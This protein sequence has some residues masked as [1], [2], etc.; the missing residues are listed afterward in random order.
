MTAHPT[1]ARRRTT[2][3]KHARIFREL[4]ALDDAARPDADAARE[5]ILATVQELWGSDELRAMSLTVLDEVRGG[6]VHFTSTLADDRPAALPRPRGALARR[7]PGRHDRRPAAAAL[8]LL[9]RRRPRRQPVRD[10]ADDRRGARAAAR[11]LPAVP[12][13]AARAASPA[14]C[15][16]RSGSTGPRSGS[17]PILEPGGERVPGAGAAA[18]ATLN[19]EEPYR[20]ALTFIRERVRATAAAT[21][22]RLRRAGRAARRPARD[23]A[24]A[25]AHG[26]E[27]TAAGDLRDVIRQVEV[28]G[29][30]FAT[31]DIRQHAKVH[32]AALARA[33]RR[34]S[35]SATTMRPAA[36]AERAEL[37][38]AHIA[39]RRPLIPAD[40]SRF[41]AATREAIE[42]FRMVKRALHGRAPRRDRRLHHLRN[43]GCRRRARGA[44]ADEGGEPRACRRRRGDAPDRAAV[45]GRRDARRPLP[46]RSRQLLAHAGLPERAG[47][48][49]R[50]AGDDDRLLGL[51]QGRRLRGLG[52]GRPTAPR[53]GSPRCSAATASAG[54]SSTA[55]AAPSVAA[56]AR[57]TARSWRCRRAPSTAG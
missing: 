51:Q 40:I 30:H 47:G 48:C 5:R 17:M 45:R 22:R 14:G 46:R 52:L 20:R 23:R 15:R 31:L 6:L 29:F 33:V 27:F 9:D 35:G 2:I 44:A 7:F 55:G 11:A 42:T 12:R 8:R 34:R 32:R 3:D 1:E 24:V 49:R 50:R 18:R 19:P 26:G 54:S 25:D 41:S 43:R 39:D 16:C 37:L 10:P 38:A 57:P 28:F 53:A 36:G 21:R 4:R 56:A 13:G